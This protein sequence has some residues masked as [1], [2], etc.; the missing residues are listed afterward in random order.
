MFY[1]HCVEFIF[2]ILQ[3]ESTLG[4]RRQSWLYYN[5]KYKVKAAALC[6]ES[7]GQ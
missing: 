1:F 7:N 4:W 2:C 3:Q 5:A 6:R